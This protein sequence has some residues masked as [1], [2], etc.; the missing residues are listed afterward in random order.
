MLYKM[1]LASE[2]WVVSVRCTRS[3]TRSAPGTLGTSVSTLE[4]LSD[5]ASPISMR[6]LTMGE[7][8]QI[9]A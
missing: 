9:T 6:L 1:A 7:A 2:R 3:P 5:G 8:F 4:T